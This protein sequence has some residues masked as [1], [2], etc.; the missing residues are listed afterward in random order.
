MRTNIEARQVQTF[1]VGEVTD[2]RIKANG[3]A[4]KV[5]IDG[6]YSDKIRAVIREICTNAFDAHAMAGCPDKPFDLQLPNN[7]D[8]VFRVRDYGVGM[9]HETIMHLYTTV[10]ESSKEDTNEQV[11]KFGLG[12][13]SPFAYTDTFTVTAFDGSEKRLY[14]AFIG[15]AYVPQ[16]ALM[17]VTPSTEP[18]GIEVQFPVKTSDC[19]AFQQA[20]EATLIGFD[21]LPNVTGASLKLDKLN[22]VISGNGWKLV[23]GG[24]YGMKAHAK[25]GCV[26]YP[27]DPAAID[28]TTQFERAILMSP[29]FIDFPIGDLEIS[30]SRESIGYDDPTKKNIRRRIEEIACEIVDIYQKYIDAE[31]TMW[32]ACIKFRSLIR[33]GLDQAV[34]DILRARLTYKGKPLKPTVDV[35]HVLRP[36]YD[37]TFESGGVRAMHLTRTTLEK[38]RYGGRRASMKFE[39]SSYISVTAGE[40]AI[41]FDDAKS[42]ASMPQA[43]IRHWWNGLDGSDDRPD[44]VLWIKAE[45]NSIGLKRLLVT[46]GRPDKVIRLADL[47]RPPADKS[48]Y[49]RRPT[50]VKIL[51]H[52]SWQ[53]TEIDEDEEIIYVELNRRDTV[54]YMPEIKSSPSQVE[55]IRQAL[56]SLGYLDEGTEIYGI[57]QTHARKIAVNEHWHSLWDVVK[58]AVSELYDPVKAGL[59]RSYVN[60]MGEW[61]DLNKFFRML[62]EWEDFEGFSSPTSP[63]SILYNRWV[64]ISEGAKLSKMYEQALQ[65]HT[66]IGGSFP[67]IDYINL[68]KEEA[69]FTETY[70]L[71]AYVLSRNYIDHNL[72]SYLLEYVN[73]I[74]NVSVIA[75]CDVNSND[76]AAA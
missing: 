46:L 54:G 63:A 20:A 50:K 62:V 17:G 58:G 18:R 29:F 22:V 21:V 2:F 57:P 53:E 59:A 26:V 74:D 32:R 44:A 24:P 27:L 45:E 61:S 70:P 7:F 65:L 66:S 3:K 69:A 60:K 56:V 28:Q 19:W 72:R 16:I 76:L 36:L 49:A 47:E 34:V 11:G 30:A 51:R 43:R 75:D 13:K 48:D 68:K 40:I 15:P 4:F 10:F 52:T 71:S 42:P 9:D 55:H 37:K 64:E 73:A 23:R 67:P 35:G 14:S 25:Q 41:I 1:G 12:S 38:G 8:P 33:G 39:P 31:P 5:L 6:L